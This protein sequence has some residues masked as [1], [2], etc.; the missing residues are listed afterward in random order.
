[1][2]ALR[3][4]ESNTDPESDALDVEKKKLKDDLIAL[5]EAQKEEEQEEKNVADAK[6]TQKA[7]EADAIAVA[8]NEVTALATAEKSAAEAEAQSE[9]D[10]EELESIETETAELELEK[11]R[12][13][14]AAKESKA[15]LRHDE[16]IQH[17]EEE[18]VVE[19]KHDVE[20][21]EANLA[22]EGSYSHAVARAEA[23]HEALKEAERFESVAK[24]LMFDALRLH[25]S[26][27]KAARSAVIKV[28]E[29]RD[30]A[31]AETAG[32]GVEL[33][34]TILVDL[35][36]QVSLDQLET[37]TIEEAAS[38]LVGVP[39]D[40]VSVNRQASE[41]GGVSLI[42]IQMID[43]ASGS[44]ATVYKKVNNGAFEGKSLGGI[45]VSA[46]K[47][48]EKSK[49][50]AEA[51]QMVSFDV[52]LD[53][54]AIELDRELLLEQTVNVFGIPRAQATV[55]NETAASE[56][57]GMISHHPSLHSTPW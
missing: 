38:A 56:G 49:T 15:V 44:K 4:G 18:G 3:L 14:R 51:A 34:E 6:E 19:A 54:A 13:D 50:R 33:Q 52:T 5:N 11:R 8:E 48:V 43:P 55:R 26:K 1:M 36:L 31:E 39:R 30:A 10:K 20:V 47:S 53:C 17:A 28:D 23:A 25:D 41:G 27:Q 45:Q 12:A 9:A 21:S 57:A 32:G 22:P 42:T 40:Q 46:V 7:L 24:D 29:L 35:E 37:D 16:E 2:E